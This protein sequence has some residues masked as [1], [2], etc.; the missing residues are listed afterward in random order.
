MN[1]IK[2]LL[3]KLYDKVRPDFIFYLSGV[4]IL[5]TDKLGRLE[6]TLD[7]CKKKMNLFYLF[8]NR[9]EF[10]YNVLWEVVIQKKSK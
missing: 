3:S 8:V 4:D 7:G 2:E 1:I 9:K 10:L 6:I 5:K